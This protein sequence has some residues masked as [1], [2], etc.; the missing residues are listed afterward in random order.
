MSKYKVGDELIIVTDPNEETV[1]L[2]ELTRLKIDGDFAQISWGLKIV[3]VTFDKPYVT[4]T[5]R[6]ANGDI[7]KVKDTLQDLVNKLYIK[8]G[9]MNVELIVDKNDDVWLIDVGPRNG[10]NMI[11]DLLGYIFNINVVEMSIKVAMG[12]APDISKYKPVPFYATH[13]LHSDKNGIFDK[14]I[15]SEEAE[16]FIIKKCI[17]KKKGDKVEYFDNASK[18][19]GIIF[20][21]FDSAGS[22]NR[23]LQ[24][25][26][27][28]IRILLK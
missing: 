12:D 3:D 4:L 16:H 21:K 6:N 19:L 26:D 10:G 2:N 27:N 1:K 18:A 11:P 22:M 28:H 15:F 24:N 7:N 14:I 20:F 25:I 8:D 9:A 5:Y 23:I 13:N 17:Y